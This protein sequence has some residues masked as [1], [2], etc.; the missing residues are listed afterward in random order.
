MPKLASRF[1]DG[2]VAIFQ[3]DGSNSKIPRRYHDELVSALIDGKSYFQCE[4]MVG[5]ERFIVL[6]SIVDV[7]CYTVAGLHIVD[8]Y[9]AEDKA[10]SLRE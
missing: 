2:Y 3:A 9:D 4:D 7:I 10:E 1:P 8:D 6:K 5:S